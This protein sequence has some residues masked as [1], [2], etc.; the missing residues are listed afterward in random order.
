MKNLDKA[1]VKI[2]KQQLNSMYVFAYKAKASPSY[3]LIGY[4]RT[5]LNF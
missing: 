3:V 2:E 5:C 4:P 1:V